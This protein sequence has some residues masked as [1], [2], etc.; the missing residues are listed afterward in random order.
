VVR[1]S[2][3]AVGRRRGAHGRLGSLDLDDG[4]QPYL[5]TEVASRPEYERE[6]LPGTDAFFRYDHDAEP[7][8]STRWLILTGAYA[9][10]A[11]RAPVSIRPFV[12]I[13]FH[14]LREGRGGITPDGLYG[15]GSFWNLNVGS[16]IYFG[17]GPMRMGS[18]GALDAMSAM[19]EHEM[20][21]IMNPER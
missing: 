2:R 13:Q 1:A 14:S 5:R 3:E 12:E 9:Y 6:G 17:G 7:I 11:T 15:T 4:H 21:P 18:Y 20:G 10:R 16:R 8:G 19:G